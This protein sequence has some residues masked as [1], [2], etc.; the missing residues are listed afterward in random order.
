[1]VRGEKIADAAGL[2]MFAMVVSRILGYVRDVLIYARFGQN[3]I[4]DAYQAAFSI[5]DFLYLLLVGGALSSAFIPVFAGYLATDQEDE[6]WKVASIVFNFVIVLMLLGIGLGLV[7]TPQLMRLLVPGFDP[8]TMRLA[9]TLTRIMFVQ[10]FFMALSGV[11]MGVLHSYRYFTATAA[12]AILYNLGII[13]VG[14]FLSPYLGIMAFSLGVVVGAMANFFVQLPPLLRRGLR[15][16]FSFDLSHPGVRRLWQLMVPVLASLSVTQLNLFVN[17]NLAS[18]LAPGL[19]AALRTAQRLMQLPVGTF[20]VA[21]AVAAFPSLTAQAAQGKYAAYRHTLAQGL[22]SMFFLMLPATLGLMAL[23]VP[24]VRLLFEQGRFT[25]A[26]TQAT[27]YALLFYAVGIV[28]YGSLQLLNR[29][30]YAVQD[31]ATPMLVGMFTIALNIWLNLILIGRL[32]H[33]GL[34][35][36][37]SL[38]GIFNM[39]LLLFLLRRRLGP[40]GGRRLALSAAKSLV[41]A[42]LA[43]S[44]AW[45][46]A[47]RLEPQVLLLGKLGQVQQVGAAL[48]VALGVFLLA[49]VALRMEETGQAWQ[50]VRRRLGR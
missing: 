25:P 11:T 24:I 33:G 16:H 38:A 15:Y 22:R 18:T 13:L 39:V 27:A 49:A 37:Y 2:L 29:A 10:A 41:A 5:P 44:A 48:A 35:L 17:Q 40:M 23:G 36:A 7:Y 47:G 8:P 45:T 28:A 6:A 43:A 50:L 1:M 3:N 34:A 12:A 4:T 26:A 14:W 20:A 46:V 9:V 42:L 19:V 32:G 31:T 30:F 21:L